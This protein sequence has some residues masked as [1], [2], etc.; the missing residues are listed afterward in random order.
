MTNPGLLLVWRAASSR[1]LEESGMGFSGGVHIQRV[2]KRRGRAASAAHF[3]LSIS[4][5][6]GRDAALVPERIAGRTAHSYDG[7][8]S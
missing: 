2:G 4:L 5:G 8:M 3:T 6:T 1:T 7:P